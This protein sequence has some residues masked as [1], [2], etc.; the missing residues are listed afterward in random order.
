MYLFGPMTSRNILAQM[1]KWSTRP[2][3]CDFQNGRKSLGCPF[4][5]MGLKFKCLQ[6]MYCWNGNFIR[7]DI[8][9]RK[10]INIFRV[11]D[12]KPKGHILKVVGFVKNRLYRKK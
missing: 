2:R 12:K 3:F 7:I 1:A 4:S 6:I 5:Y 11:I 9:L 10:N 8:V